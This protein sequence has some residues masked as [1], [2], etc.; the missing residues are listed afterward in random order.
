MSV[1]DPM[2]LLT[3]GLL[4]FAGMQYWVM[5]SGER[6]RIAEREADQQH[7]LNHAYQLLWA[8]SW[9]LEAI[10]DDW[11]DADLV[12]LALSSDLNPDFVRSGDWSE[13]MRAYARLG[14][15]SGYLGGVA[16]ARSQELARAISRFREGIEQAA[17]EVQGETIGQRATRAR[18]SVSP[19]RLQFAEKE[20]QNGVRDLSLLVLDAISHS[21]H[22]TSRIE[23]K[24]KDTFYS[25]AARAAAVA[26]VRRG[27]ASR[28]LSAQSDSGP[29]ASTP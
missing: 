6:N 7:D 16:L 15:E 5:R 28:M 27:E 23:L 8:E 9:R 21:P 24:F 10:A 29:G 25:K 20:I 22:G 26:F 19:Q 4:F 11:A 18:A 14:L 13:Q 1:F 3:F 17:P 12:F 2:N